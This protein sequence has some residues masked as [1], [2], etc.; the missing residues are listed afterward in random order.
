MRPSLDCCRPMPAETSS[1]SMY[2][3]RKNRTAGSHSLTRTTSNS[4]SMKIIKSLNFL[5]AA[6]L[7][8]YANVSNLDILP[9][10]KQFPRISLP[11]TMPM[12]KSKHTSP[13]GHGSQFL[14]KSNHQEPTLDAEPSIPHSLP[15]NVLTSHLELPTLT[16]NIQSLSNSPQIPSLWIQWQ[17]FTQCHYGSISKLPDPTQLVPN[18]YHAQSIFPNLHR[19]DIQLI[20]FSNIVLIDRSGK[21]RSSINHTRFL[22][23]HPARI[24]GGAVANSKQH[25][26]SSR[27][28]GGTRWCSCGHCIGSTTCSNRLVH[29][30]NQQSLTLQSTPNGQINRGPN[31]AFF[32]GKQCWFTK[33]NSFT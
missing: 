19:P 22:N 27:R 28:N 20:E 6:Q 21:N 16:Y 3:T 33:A 32:P 25:V 18:I 7:A 4:N 2:Y 5:T 31:I 30:Q 26:V 8:F 17:L 29:C 14:F 13:P 15:L 1:K 9:R 12:F 23:L 24:T 10:I 11:N